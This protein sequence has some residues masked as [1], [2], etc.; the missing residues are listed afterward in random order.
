MRVFNAIG[1]LGTRPLLAVA[2][3]VATAARWRYSD[4]I[5]PAL[6][7]PL[8]I[9]TAA[10]ALIVVTR[11]NLVAQRFQVP[12][13]MAYALCGAVLHPLAHATVGAALFP[14][15]ACGACGFRI[16]SVRLAVGIAA[17]AAVVSA[18]ML[19]LVGRS[20]ADAAQQWPWWV[21]LTVGLPVYIGIARRYQSEALASA[22]QAAV[23]ARRAAASDAHSAALE[24]RGRIAREVHDV[25]A[26]SLSGIALQLDL[27]ETLYRR[28]RGDEAMA[29]V[30]RARTLAVDSIAETRSAVHALRDGAPRVADALHTMA[31]TYGARLE[32]VGDPA[33]LAPEAA[34]TFVR[35]AQ[36]ALTNA[37]KHA[38]GATVDLRLEAAD[39]AVTL[40]ARNPLPPGDAGSADPGIG[41]AG[42]TERVALLGGSLRAGPTMSGTWEVRAVI[43]R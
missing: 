35:A 43:P 20:Y 2:T 23:D 18:G 15:L 5:A 1:D 17:V 8:F 27:A 38:P 7:L 25:V 19:W 39:D 40:T 34:H 22:R 3:I 13:L 33:G 14:Y 26:H 16:R 10:L 9:V 11:W 28:D 24:E 29:A 32:I 30:H 21:G 36:E 37:A 31:E 41:L 4:I 12:L 42:M 6:A